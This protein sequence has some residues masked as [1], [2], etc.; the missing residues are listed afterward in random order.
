MGLNEYDLV[1]FANASTAVSGRKALEEAGLRV[2]VM[3]TPREVSVSCGLSLR[4]P[5]EQWQNARAVLD[6]LGIPPEERHFYR[7]EHRDRRQ[8]AQLL[9]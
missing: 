9:D 1:A 8:T 4:L 3:P 5:A 7:M 2:C 6:A